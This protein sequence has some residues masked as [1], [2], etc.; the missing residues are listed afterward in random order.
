TQLSIKA[1][2]RHVE[3]LVVL[4][5]SGRAVAGERRIDTSVPSRPS[6]HR[7]PGGLPCSDVR[8][9]AGTRGDAFADEPV[10]AVA[11]QGPEQERQAQRQGRR[12]P[13]AV[14]PGV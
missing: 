12:E 3:E 7:R 4:A 8:S 1:L 14:E 11:G 5:L 13:V 6:R 10:D 2:A 9:P